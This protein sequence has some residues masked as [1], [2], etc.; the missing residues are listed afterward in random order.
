MKKT[1]LTTGIVFFCLSCSNNSEQ[2]IIEPKQEVEVTLDYTFVENGSML[3][4]GESVYTSFY[5]SYIKT[6]KLTPKTYELTFKNKEGAIV[7]VQRGYWDKKDGIRLPEGEYQ[8]T[9]TS[10]PTKNYIDTVSIMFDEKVTIKKDQSSLVLTAKYDSYLLMFDTNTISSIEYRT[11][12]IGNNNYYSVSKTTDIY[13]MFLKSFLFT[14]NNYLRVKRIT[15]YESNI[16][17]DNLPFEKGKYYYFNDM[18]NSFN[19][20][21]MLSGN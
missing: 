6:K 16:Y 4:S 7:A 19:I 13:C 18:T 1:L 14:T 20:P 9:G 2:E 17:L 5:N 21:P 10:A 11:S 3:K 8:I 12:G 15:K